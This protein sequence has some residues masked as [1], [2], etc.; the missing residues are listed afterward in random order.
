MN[1]IEKQE[2]VK[3]LRG[4]L[5]DGRNSTA[6]SD[7]GAS[8]DADNGSDDTAFR[9]TF[10]DAGREGTGAIGHSNE[11][12]GDDRQPGSNR[13]S[14]KTS[15]KRSGQADRRP[16]QSDSSTTSD[17]AESTATDERAIGRLFS[18]ESIKDRLNPDKPEGNF[19]TQAPTEAPEVKKRGI[20]GWP[21]GKPRK[22][23]DSGQGAAGGQQQES[24]FKVPIIRKGNV[25][26]S[27]EVAEL[28]EP[29]I[30]ALE[31]DFQAIDT[32]LWSRQ[33]SVGQDSHEQPVWSDLDTEEIEALTRIMLKWGQHNETAATVVR[34]VIDA[35]DYVEV[36]TIFIPRITH[37][38]Q[39]MRETHKPRVK[40]GQVQN[41]SSN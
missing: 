3:A 7:A 2:K 32:Y 29:F 26:S 4:T 37:T 27:K 8:T 1:E 30:H 15:T 25:L 6:V 5:R 33:K 18:N 21:K 34:G 14:P 23:K 13:R 10:Q 19:S 35:S 31:S 9:T 41:E 20:G 22:Q 17:A 40:R 12:A 39:I 38:V 28:N 11:A 16:S 36:G 24:S